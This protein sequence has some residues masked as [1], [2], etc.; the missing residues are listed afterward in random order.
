MSTIT[1]TQINTHLHSQQ[2]SAVKIQYGWVVIGV[3]IGQFW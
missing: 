3:A 2:P 1:Y